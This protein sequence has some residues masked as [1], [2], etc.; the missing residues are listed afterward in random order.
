MVEGPGEIILSYEE[1]QKSYYF[2]Y[3]SLLPVGIQCFFKKVQVQV[4][5]ISTF[6]RCYSWPAI[7][8]SK[9]KCISPV[10]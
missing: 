5:N 10:K 1:K 7:P 6:R 8:N 2:E 9:E 4:Y 3:S